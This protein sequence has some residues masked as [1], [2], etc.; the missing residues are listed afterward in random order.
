MAVMC[1]ALVATGT[2][3]HPP[4]MAPVPS[5]RRHCWWTAEYLSVAPVWVASRFANALPSVGITNVTKETGPDSAWAFGGPAP[6]Q[7]M[8]REITFAFR[9]VA[10]PATDSVRCAWR[11]T[12]DAPV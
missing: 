11:G 5:E 7:G 3:R 2:C 10:Y 6:V 1:V 4:E 9:A 12:A 8:V